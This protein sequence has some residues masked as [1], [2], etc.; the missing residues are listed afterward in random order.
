MAVVFMMK[1]KKEGM[2]PYTCY[3]DV[4]DAKAYLSPPYPTEPGPYGTI[5]VI[6]SLGDEVH[7]G[8]DYCL[9]SNSVRQYWCQLNCFNKQCWAVDSNTF[10]SV[11]F[12]CNGGCSN[13]ICTVVYDY[14]YFI[15][16]KDSY[17]SGSDILS[18]FITNANKW[19]M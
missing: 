19:V 12:N 2:S 16:N 13:G 18:T 8:Q 10:F 1:G 11:D 9:S 4:G 3:S 5:W 7:R 15:S 14:T 6:D 17:L